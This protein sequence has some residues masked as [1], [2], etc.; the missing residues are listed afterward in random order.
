MHFRIC[1]FVLPLVLAACSEPYAPGI[2]YQATTPGCTHWA[3]GSRFELPKQISVFAGK[4]EA[5][6]GA[7]VELS[8]AYFIPR[9]AEASFEHQEFVVTLPRGAAVSRGTVVSVERA[10]SPVRA[11]TTVVLSELPKSLRGE[12]AAEETMY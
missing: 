11:E 9:G 12:P 8:L 3:D 6:S 10:V 4:P 2:L 1:L 7:G 5:V